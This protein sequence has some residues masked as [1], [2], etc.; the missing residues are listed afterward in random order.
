VITYAAIPIVF[1]IFP[2][3]RMLS[4][5]WATAGW[6]AVFNATA[7]G[8]LAALAKGRLA[9]FPGTLNPL[10]VLSLGDLRNGP[11]AAFQPLFGVAAGSILLAAASLVVRYRRSSGDQRF[12]L[13]WVA[14]AVGSFAVFAA[15]SS[16]NVW[17][18]RVDD[19]LG[20]IVPTAIPVAITMAILRYRIYDID[21]IVSRTVSYAVVTGSLVGVYVGCV[22][23]LTDVLPFDGSV[24]T[25]ASVL[26]A[27]ALFTPLRRRVQHAVDR[28]F[29]RARYDA[30]ATMAA[31]ASR[32][33][34]EIDLDAVR[35]DLIGAVTRTV[36]PAHAC[37]WLRRM[38]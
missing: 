26:V 38:P 16:T 7:L 5:R 32:L 31:F 27:V 22:A 13:K 36:E 2:D 18:N 21:R 12:Q 35:R 34:D 1:L 14:W 10:G 30:E 3:G 25:A 8:L 24:G 29:N 33:R 28:R 17:S 20:A 4:R 15:L 9:E 37:V 6:L 11:P 23:L 19:I